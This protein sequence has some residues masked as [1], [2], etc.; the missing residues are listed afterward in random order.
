VG[1]DSKLRHC[2]R[3]LPGC[4]Q[5]IAF[6]AITPLRLSLRESQTSKIPHPLIAQKKLIAVLLTPP[7]D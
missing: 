7:V 4:N 6:A 5:V 3:F 2:Q 1:W